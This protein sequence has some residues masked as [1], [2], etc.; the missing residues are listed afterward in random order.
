MLKTSHQVLSIE[1]PEAEI[2]NHKNGWKSGGK[3]YSK[4]EW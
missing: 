2:I 4:K 1:K 3:V